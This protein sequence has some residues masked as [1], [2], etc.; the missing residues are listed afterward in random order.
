MRN[1]KKLILTVLAATLLLGATP[2]FAQL[3][4]TWTGEGKGN[5]HPYPGVVIYPWQQWKGE[6]F[7]SPDEDVLLFVGEWFDANGSHGT[8]TGKILPIGTQELAICKGVWTW[9]DPSGDTNQPVYG[10]DFLM[11]F[12]RKE[13]YCKGTWSSIWLSSSQ[14]G[15]MEGKKVE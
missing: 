10:G 4:G 3:I 1:N 6:V 8:F 13:G 7:E 5:C 15:T 9:F 14:K 2:A 11:N 12:Y